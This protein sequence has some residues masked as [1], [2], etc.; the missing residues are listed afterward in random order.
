MQAEPGDAEAQ[1][2][3]DPPE[4]P[5]EAST[6]DP[7][8]TQGKYASAATR[9]FTPTTEASMSRQVDSVCIQKREL[10]PYLQPGVRTGIFSLRHVVAWR[11]T[12]TI[13]PDTSLSG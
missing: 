10:T 9:A 13:V 1:C 12:V 4:T 11:L 6:R 8:P 5:A 2:R 7:L 3:I